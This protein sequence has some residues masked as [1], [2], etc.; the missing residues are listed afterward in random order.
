MGW[1]YS[2]DVAHSLAS[3]AATAL[4]TD[5]M[6]P[7]TEGAVRVISQREAARRLRLSAR[8]AEKAAGAGRISPELGGGWMS[9]SSGHSWPRA[10]IPRARLIPPLHLLGRRVVSQVRATRWALRA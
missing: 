5:K 2:V 3:P 1:V 8:R 10:P 6:M 4:S 9:R 7:P